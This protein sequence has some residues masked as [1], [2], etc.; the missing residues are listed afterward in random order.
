MGRRKDN[1]NFGRK[2]GYFEKLAM[3]TAHDTYDPAK[4]GYGSDAEW[5][6]L[7]NVRMGFEEARNYKA[8]S[9]RK[10]GSDWTVLSEIAG[11]HIDENSVWSEIKSAF[12]KASMNSHPDRVTQHGKDP[13]V[14]E[15][16]FKCASAAF[17]MLEDIYT[18]QGR[19]PK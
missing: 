14:A 1:S 16:E 3:G 17:A 12:R 2:P 15:E 7:F 11:V 9:K 10:W 5:Q 19:L 18:V 4:E 8:A 13:A 6:S